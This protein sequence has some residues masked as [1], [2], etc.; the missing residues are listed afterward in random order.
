MARYYFTHST[1]GG[2]DFPAAFRGLG[3]VRSIMKNNVAVM[4]LTATATKGTQEIIS[5]HNQHKKRIHRF[6]NSRKRNIIYSATKTATIPSEFSQYVQ[7]LR[8]ERETYPILLIF[9]RTIS[10]CANI[11]IRILSPEA[12]TRMQTPNWCSRYITLSSSGHVHK[13]HHTRC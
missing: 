7:N 6:S 8:V 5:S 13:C 2:E 10:D 1:Q 11:I 4:A 12:W 9:C 3:D